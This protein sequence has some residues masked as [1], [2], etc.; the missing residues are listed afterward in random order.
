MPIVMKLDLDPDRTTAA[1]KMDNTATS[2]GLIRTVIT[3][4]TMIAAAIATVMYP[5]PIASLRAYLLASEAAP[6]VRYL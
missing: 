4:P 3:K 6:V 2:I 1:I 5:T